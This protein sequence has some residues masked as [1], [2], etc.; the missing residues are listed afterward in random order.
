LVLASLAFRPSL[1]RTLFYFTETATGKT[2]M[3]VR[4][5]PKVRGTDARLA[6][7]AGELA[8][9]P[10]NPGYTPL[11]GKEVRVLRGFVRNQAAYV[12]LSVEALE[13]GPGAVWTREAQ[14]LFKK[15]VF[16]NFGNV[17]KI[18]LYMDGIE[19]Y[20]EIPGS[21]VELKK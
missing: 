4:Y 21:G 10:L 2:R 3:E 18:Y 5:L 7:F 12:D 9:G 17:D 1:R 13:S 14:E 6:L 16:T 11:F 20:G 15:N 19:V 8:L